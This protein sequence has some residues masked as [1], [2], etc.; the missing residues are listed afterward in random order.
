M[1]CVVLA[2]KYIE[3]NQ[4]SVQDIL[5]KTGSKFSYE[6][7]ADIERTILATLSWKVRD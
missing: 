3:V 2:T 4:I 5:R 7:Y 6:E 1:A